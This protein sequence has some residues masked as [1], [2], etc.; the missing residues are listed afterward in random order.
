MD[1]VIISSTSRTRVWVTILCHGYW[2]DSNNTPDN[3]LTAYNFYGI[4]F[5]PGVDD[6]KYED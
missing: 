5:S 6:G 2:S 3:G 1:R 4:L